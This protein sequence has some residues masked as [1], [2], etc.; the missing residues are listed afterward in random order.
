MPKRANALVQR[1]KE[2]PTIDYENDW[3][4]VTLFIGGNDICWW[5]YDKEY[6]SPDNFTKHISDALVI[7]HAEV[8][9]TQTQMLIIINLF[10]TKTPKYLFPIGNKP[11]LYHQIGKRNIFIFIT[12]QYNLMFCV[13]KIKC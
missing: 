7:L 5:C 12:N 4:V 1:L 9:Y 11:L 2:D 10:R 8:Y 3:K 6:R 13:D